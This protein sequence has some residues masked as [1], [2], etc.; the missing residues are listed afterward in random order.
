MTIVGLD[1]GKCSVHVCVLERMPYDIKR[2]AG[3]YDPLIL[4]SKWDDLKKLL[5]LGDTYAIEPTGAYSRIFIDFL[6][7]NG[8]R[9]LLVYDHRIT[10][11]RILKGL[12]NKNDKPDALAIAAFTM[13]HLDQPTAFINF[14]QSELRDAFNNLCA[15]RRGMQW[16]QSNLGLRLCYEVPEWVS[17][18]EGSKRKWL[19]QKTPALWRFIAGE[20]TYNQRRR[21]AE[22]SETCGSGLSDHSQQLAKQLLYWCAQEFSAEQILTDCL[23]SQ[24]YEPYQRVFDQFSMGPFI[25]AGILTVS[26]PM[27]R[28]LVEGR[29]NIDYIRGPKTKRPSGRTKRNHSQAAFKLYNG[30]GRVENKSG[31]SQYSEI[32][33]G[34]SM[35]RQIWFQHITASTLLRKPAG[36]ATQL[37]D[38]LKAK[39]GSETPWLNTNITQVISERLSV[40]PMVASTMIHYEELKVSRRWHDQRM[41]TVAGRLCNQLYKEL[42]KIVKN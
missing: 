12:L 38:P 22:L 35:L 3:K 31:K 17:I 32:K 25:R 27:N 8:K 37:L 41:M 6:R 5:T 28:F 13:E 29:E 34:S 36:F 7:Q 2:F 33:G 30:L 1:C 21:E 10:A 42:I 11:Y 15:V 20:P 9:V 24:E 26:Y 19:E 4:E 40:N 18:Y 14:Q 39:F 16:P 23:N